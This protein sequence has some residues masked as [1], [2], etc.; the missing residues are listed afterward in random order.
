MGPEQILD[1]SKKLLF[2]KFLAKEMI[3]SAISK[4]IYLSDTNALMKSIYL[5]GAEYI[6]D[7]QPEKARDDFFEILHLSKASNDPVM[8][9]KSYNALGL[10][11]RNNK[12]YDKADEFFNLSLEVSIKNKDTMSWA[13]VLQNKSAAFRDQLR[14]EEGFTF[15]DSCQKILFNHKDSKEYKNLI[16]LKAKMFSYSKNFD[17][18]YYYQKIFVD[19]DRDN[20]NFIPSQTESELA[21]LALLTG[22]IKEAENHKNNALRL[23]DSTLNKNSLI[24]IYNN[25]ANYYRDSKQFKLAYKF[26]DTASILREQAL[27]AEFDG[28][29]SQAESE[30]EIFKEKQT[31]KNLEDLNSLNTLKI[32]NRNNLLIGFGIILILVFILTYL[33]YTN[34]AKLQKQ[35]RIIEQK[36]EDLLEANQIKDKFYSIISHDIKNPLLGIDMALEKIS[37]DEKYDKMDI[38]RFSQLRNTS[39]S[40]IQL[41]NN[42]LDWSN[43]Q[44]GKIEYR[45]AEVDAS[46]LLDLVLSINQSL[47]N[48]KR[49]KIIKNYD[50]NLKIYVDSNMFVSIFHNLVNNALKFSDYDSVVEVNAKSNSEEL[51]FEVRDYGLGM[52]KETI[53]SLFKLDK[54]FRQISFKKHSGTGLGLKICKEFVDTNGGRI[55]VKS[56]IN[57]GSSFLVEFPSTNKLIFI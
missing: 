52:N 36:N 18:A 31:V 4:S 28:K 5:R 46:E 2:N 51:C 56:S 1:S 39:N 21:H 32:K 33:I 12:I 6:R 41:F 19:L 10:I 53:E 24:N 15:L 14:F 34:R 37:K 47:A 23:I 38:K 44:S 11:N 27:T 50:D 29:I 45:P 22:R 55:S 7:G 8:I 17:S 3:D 54:D 13:L 30:F 16:Y 9:A 40:L 26:R 20:Y 42:L 43:L 35:N 48:E 57:Q 25:L 49:V